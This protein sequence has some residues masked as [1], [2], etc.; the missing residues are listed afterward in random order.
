M[1]TMK[2]EIK[3]KLRRTI[4]AYKIAITISLTTV[5]ILTI[6]NLIN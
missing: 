4:I 3:A 6:N 5:V 2:P 1:I